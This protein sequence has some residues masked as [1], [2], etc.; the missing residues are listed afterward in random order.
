MPITNQICSK[1]YEPEH[2]KMNAEDTPT[3]EEAEATQFL[4]EQN[5][6]IP[7]SPHLV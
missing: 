2:L 1:Q 4:R 3:I 5:L 6:S 7:S